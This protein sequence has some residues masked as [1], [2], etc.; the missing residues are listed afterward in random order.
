MNLPGFNLVPHWPYIGRGWWKKDEEGTVHLMP[1]TSKSA[2][3]NARSSERAASVDQGAGK[4]I[5][6]KRIIP[7]LGFCLEGSYFL[8][9]KGPGSAP[10]PGRF[11]QSPPRGSPSCAP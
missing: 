11:P 9:L 5:S 10:R 6:P 8:S 3:A 7:Y 4:P 1:K 2:G